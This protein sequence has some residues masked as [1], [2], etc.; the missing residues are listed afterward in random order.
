MGHPGGKAYEAAAALHDAGLHLAEHGVGLVV[1]R[2]H[3]LIQLVLHG[4]D[5]GP[6]PRVVVVAVARAIAAG[7]AALV[8]QRLAG[9][10][11]VDPLHQVGQHVKAV[12]EVHDGVVQGVCAAGLAYGLP[13]DVEEGL[14]VSVPLSVQLGIQAVEDAGDIARTLVT[15]H[16]ITHR[17]AEPAQVL[18]GADY[19]RFLRQRASAATRIAPNLAA[20]ADRSGPRQLEL[21]DLSQVDV[22][23]GRVAVIGR[24]R[25]VRRRSTAG[26]VHLDGVARWAE[27]IRTL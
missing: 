1:S 2:P 15:Q 5:G 21:R 17:V 23:R 27:P 25:Q 6:K 24:R 22:P 26:G 14:L 7:P 4:D 10:R 12:E 8:D 13:P 3:A 11:G 9:H 20:L 16:P 18:P 19:A